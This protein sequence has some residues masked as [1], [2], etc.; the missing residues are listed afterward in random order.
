MSVMSESLMRTVPITVILPIDHGMEIKENH[1]FKTLYLLHG[2][3]GN[4]LDWIS[5]TNIQQMAEERNLCVVMPSG[6]NMFYMDVPE[7]GMNYSSFILELVH[8]TRKAF[9]LSNRKEDTFIGGLSMGGYGSLMNGLKY[10][11]TFGYILA[12]SPVNNFAYPDESFIYQSEKFLGKLFDLKSARH[13]DLNINYAIAHKTSKE[14]E[15]LRIFMA[16]GKS[17]SFLYHSKKMK[18]CFDQNEFEITYLE[19]EGSHD[20][21]F[22]SKMLVKGFEWL[23]LDQKVKGINSGNIW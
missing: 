13:S 11:D 23:P 19:T 16:C 3:F 5:N 8:L 21:N 7:L 4:H 9:H 22:W 1:P 6:E 12:F 18:E 17:D 15:S 10:C 2:V 20:W 14:K